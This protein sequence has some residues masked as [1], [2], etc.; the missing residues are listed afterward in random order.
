MDDA[1]I[2]LAKAAG[3]ETTARRFPDDVHEALASLAKH[4]T[5]LARTNDPTLEP[6][7]AYTGPKAAGQ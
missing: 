2:A 5:L 1:T 4:K 3:L 7:P 6:T